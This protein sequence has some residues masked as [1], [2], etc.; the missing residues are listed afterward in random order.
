VSS[1]ESSHGSSAGT[2]PPP[3]SIRWTARAGDGAR[4]RDILSRAGADDRAIAEGRVFVGRRRVR[5]GDEP[6]AEGDVVEIAASRAEVRAASIQVLL[7]TPDLVAVAKPAGVPTIPDHG[8][9]AHALL[10]L[11]AAELGVDPA[12]LHATS[13]LD[14]EVSGVVFFALSP[15]ASERL[16][17]ARATGAYERRYIAIAS[18]AP[19]PDAGRWDVPIGRARDPRLRAAK[20]PGALASTT[21]Y[22]A[23]ARGGRGEAMLAVAPV[24]GRTHQIRVHAAHAGAPLLG[25]R[26]YGGPARL[27]L[28]NGR[29]LELRR[30]ALHAFRVSV[31]DRDGER[32]VATAPVPKELADLWSALGGEASAWDVCGACPLASP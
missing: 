31:P 18:R 10:A 30:I 17:R 8:G 4:V 21:R 2:K 15:V 13:R 24:T 27:T 12:R 14:R 20:G 26:A 28:G 22:A 11:V 1:D 29:V 23:C 3:P 6:V 25:D 9:A 32:I 19:E 7:Q 5:S 16:L